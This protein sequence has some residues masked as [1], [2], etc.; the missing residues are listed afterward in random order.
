LLAVVKT[1]PGDAALGPISGHAAVREIT[2]SNMFDEADA[3]VSSSG[4]TEWTGGGGTGDYSIGQSAIVK[5]HTAHAGRS[6]RGRIFLPFL[7]EAAVTKGRIVGDA[8]TLTAP[9]WAVWTNGLEFASPHATHTVWSEL[10]GVGHS[11]D[12]YTLNPIPGFRRKR[13]NEA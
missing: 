2:V 1:G 6:G 11:V 7:T 5:L 12:N 8:L 13:A 9:A 4:L 10:H 3:A